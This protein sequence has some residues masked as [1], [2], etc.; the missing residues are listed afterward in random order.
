[1]RLAGQNKPAAGGLLGLH[2][3]WVVAHVPPHVSN[4]V[5]SCLASMLA[6]TQTPC[7]DWAVQQ[8]GMPAL[9]WLRHTLAAVRCMPALHWLRA[10]WNDPS[11]AAL[12][13]WCV[14][15]HGFPA[16]KIVEGPLNF[17]IFAVT[18]VV[19][20]VPEVRPLLYSLSSP[21]RGLTP[22]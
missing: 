18:I 13:R 16:D 21:A 1:M 20:A 12:C 19:V 7:P 14:E 5:T 8:S 22:L 4:S 15:N 17:F 3:L 10:N 6:G 9:L 11:G 2:C